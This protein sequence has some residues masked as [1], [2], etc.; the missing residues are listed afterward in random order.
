MSY[1]EILRIIER[2]GAKASDNSTQLGT[3]A[4]VEANK[5]STKGVS[6]RDNAR[7]K[8]AQYIIVDYCPISSIQKCLEG[9]LQFS[10]T[11]QYLIIANT[12]QVF[13]GNGLHKSLSE[14]LLKS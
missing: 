7:W 6:N 10:E 1:S 2:I 14:L 11:C 8:R 4:I 13:Q 3:Y 9:F 5:F 12:N